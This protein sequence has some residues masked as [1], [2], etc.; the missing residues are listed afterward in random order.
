[1]HISSSCGG[2]G[3][4]GNRTRVKASVFDN[5]ITNSQCT[6][7]RTVYNT[8]STSVVQR[9]KIFEPL[10]GVRLWYTFEGTF[11]SYGISTGNSY[12]IKFF[13]ENWWCC[14]GY[15]T[16]LFPLLLLLWLLFNQSI[17]CN[18]INKQN[19]KITCYHQFDRFLFN[20]MFV[21]SNTSEVTNIRQIHLI[22]K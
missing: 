16:K 22:N 13:C 3:Q 20:A 4:I 8:E 7:I 17:K 2:T 12:F 19:K 18:E 11:E 21:L 10:N 1:M 9:L 5:G 15:N 14:F 6:L